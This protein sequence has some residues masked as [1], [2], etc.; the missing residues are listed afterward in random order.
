MSPQ[1][2]VV[3]AEADGLP[4]PRRT[5]AAA[6]IA[7]GISLTVLDA[8]MVNIA[9]PSAARDLGLLPA[10]SVGVVKPSSSEVSGMET[11]S[12]VMSRRASE[13]ADGHATRTTGQR[14]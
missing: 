5:R 1:R 11:L 12:K 14:A 13:A 8:A 7:A 9:L 4:E 6:C 3:Q 2:E 10:E